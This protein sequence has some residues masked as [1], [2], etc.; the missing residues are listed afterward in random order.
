LTDTDWVAWHAAYEH[1]GSSL[2]RR[3][4]IVQRH[5]RGALDACAA[6]RIRLVSLCA[7]QGHD[8]IGALDGHPRAADVQ[9]R[10]VELD[11]RNCEAARA[12]APANVEIVRGDASATSAYAGAV[13]AEIVLANG[14]FG[15]ISDADIEYTVGRLPSLCA[16]SATVVWTRHRR[17]PDVTPAIRAWFAAAGFEEIAFE[18]PDG[19]IFGVGV[20][21]LGRDP[22]PFDPDVTLFEFVGSD[23]NW[24]SA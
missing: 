22:D 2:S 21:R 9:A 23:Q 3:L 4:A 15:N 7:G 11:P 24:S 1:P 8:V 16:P 18:G 12:N 14:V 19:F 10:L 13:P 5:I 6:G 17:E 20:H